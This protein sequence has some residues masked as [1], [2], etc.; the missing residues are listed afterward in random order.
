M[1]IESGT[2]GLVIARGTATERALEPG[3]HYI[4]PY[5]QQLVQRYPLREMTYLTLDDDS[6][7]PID[8]DD[9][10]L[11][12]HPFADRT[13]ATVQ[14]T[15]RFRDPLRT[16][17][18]RST[19]D[20]VRRA[21]GA[22]SATAAG[23]S[24]STRFGQ[25]RSR[26]PRYLRRPAHRAPDVASADA[27]RAQC[28]R[29]RR[30]RPSFSLTL[31]DVDLG[32]CRARCGRTTSRRRAELEREEAAGGRRAGARAQRRPRSNARDREKV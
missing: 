31:R 7:D 9:P 22:P 16:T 18:G 8:F 5:R 24:S 32:P 19:S 1:R 2:I 15:I 20:S 14:Y 27:D 28:M 4:W 12:L 11:R 6:T 25:R 23:R 3:V 13:A 10:P 17:C 29:A 21:S 30:V 26:L